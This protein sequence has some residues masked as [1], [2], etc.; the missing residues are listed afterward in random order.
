MKKTTKDVVKGVVHKAAPKST[1]G[2][3]PND[4]WSARADIAE[5]ITSRRSDLLTKFY[6]SRGWNVDYITKNKKVAQS[7]TNEFIKWKQ[8]HGFEEETNTVDEHIV[9]TDG[10]YEL[11]SKSTGKNLGKYPTKAGAEKRERQV[12]Y[13]KHQNEETLDEISNDL[14]K[15][16]T[17]KAMFDTVTGKKDRNQGMVK[18]FSRLSDNNKPIIPKKEDVGDPKAAEQSPGD[19]ANTPDDLS[20]KRS[21]RAAKMVKEIYSNHRIQE[22]LYDWEKDDKGSKSDKKEEKPY[23]QAPKSKKVDGVNDI[24]DT[25]MK[26]RLI[27]KGGKTLTGQT[28]DTV[29]I[30]PMLKNRAGLPDYKSGKDTKPKEEKQ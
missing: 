3:D 21:S 24:N 27:L 9:K 4:P 8:D 19:C 17:K 29:A 14:A 25:K 12:Q 30:D 2:T 7:K 26:A 23:G 18:A 16:Y 28:R 5:N 11:K 13:F 10:E 6:K 1:Y 15:S 22:D 20:P